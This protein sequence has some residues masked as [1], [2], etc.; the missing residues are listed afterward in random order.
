MK[1]NQMYAP[2]KDDIWM[3]VSYDFD[4]DLSL[5]GFKINIFYVASVSDYKLTKNKDLENPIITR[6]KNNITYVPNIETGNSFDSIKHVTTLSE[7]HKQK[8]D[9]LT[10]D[11]KLETKEARKIN[12]KIRKEA[13]RSRKKK[14]LQLKSNFTIADSA[15]D[16]SINYWD[17]IRPVELTKEDISSYEDKDS[18]ERLLMDPM[19][20]DSIRL[21]KT[22]FKI[23]HLLFGKTYE[24]DSSG[25]RLSFPGFLS[26]NNFFF[27]TVDG[28][29]LQIRP[30]FSTEFK[31]QKTLKYKQYYKFSTK[32]SYLESHASLRDDRLLLK[33]LPLL[34]KTLLQEN[35]Y[36]NYLSTNQKKNYFEAGYGLNQVFLLFNLE[37]F[38]GFEDMKNKT[39]GFKL[40]VPI[41][42][43]SHEILM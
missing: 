20:R 3:P 23:K 7:K 25:S 2:V 16:K 32:Q 28:L 27:N 5:F 41:F 14:S 37:I 18:L 39:T 29:P 13:K 30:S 9:K 8:I 36:L 11:K 34:N 6:I 1:I 38:T 17:S 15:E 10:L 42:S 4:V 43:D 22:R 33:R 35:I 40:V 31:K 24:Y 21:L 12:K 26:Y 19:K